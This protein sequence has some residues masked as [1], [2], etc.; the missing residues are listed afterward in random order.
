[1]STVLTPEERLRSVDKTVEAVKQD[2]IDA[3]EEEDF[4]RAVDHVSRSDEVDE[5]F[6]DRLRAILDRLRALPE[7]LE[8]TSFEREQLHHLHTTLHEI[9]DL[10]PRLDEDDG[11]PLDTLDALLVRI[12]RIRHII[13]DALDEYV[14]GIG[15]DRARVLEQIDEWLPSITRAELAK[16]LDVSERTLPRWTHMAQPPGR[17]L[18]LVAQLMAILRH[19]WTEQGVVAWF[20]RQ[21]HD[22]GKKPFV[23][24]DDPLYEHA[25]LSAARSSRSQ[26]GT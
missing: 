20:Y 18:Q 16:L 8:P 19:S 15:N 14:S 1:M 24:L 10:M 22:L 5:T 2:V 13:R 17:R 26:H 3:I 11:A 6:E 23:V 4:S 12:E 9:R 25:L 21:N 7:E